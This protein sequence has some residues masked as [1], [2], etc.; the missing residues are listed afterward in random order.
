MDHEL[1]LALLVDGLEDRRAIPGE[2]A[3]GGDGTE[4]GQSKETQ[5]APV[6]GRVRVGVVP[7]LLVV[8]VALAA[9]SWQKNDVFEVVRSLH[10][11][12]RYSLPSLLKMT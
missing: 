3:V 7:V 4:R 10:A 6:R 11:R 8:G 5:R 2:L 1:H 12:P 9:P